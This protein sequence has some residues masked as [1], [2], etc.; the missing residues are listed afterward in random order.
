MEL[1]FQIS[2]NQVRIV[3][4]AQMAGPPGDRWIAAGKGAARAL[5]AGEGMLSWANGWA[6]DARA[7]FAT[8]SNSQFCNAVDTISGE[9]DESV[10]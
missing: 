4:R 6:G 10:L 2:Y 1:A 7:R 8:S 9:S 5:G 3:G